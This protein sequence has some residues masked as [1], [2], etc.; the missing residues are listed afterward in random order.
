MIQR[1]LL[2]ILSEGCNVFRRNSKMVIQII[3]RNGRMKNT[4][5]STQASKPQVINFSFTSIIIEISILK[6]G[7]T[8]LIELVYPVTIAVLVIPLL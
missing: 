5:I 4:N 8:I 1:P 6:S 2:T 7:I 3:G